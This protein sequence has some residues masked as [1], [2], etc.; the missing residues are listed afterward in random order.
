MTTN[1]SLVRSRRGIALRA[2][3]VLLAMVLML[4]GGVPAAA[5]S[6]RAWLSVLYGGP[7]NLTDPSG[8]EVGE[9]T[10]RGK[11]V[12]LDFG[13][14]SCP[15]ICPTTLQAIAG[16]LDLLGTGAEAVQPLFVTLDPER[17]TPALLAS[18]T[19]LFH[20]RILGLSGTAEQ[21]AA[22]ARAYR[23]EYRKVV[24]KTGGD[25]FMDH[26]TTVYLLDTQGKTVA[27]FGRQSTAEEMTAVIR[28]LLPPQM[29]PA[30]P[31]PRP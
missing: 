1:R 18:Y 2:A 20:P 6:P 10:W 19:A 3:W 25:Y 12:L 9:R 30:A 21:T 16:A 8:R 27:L 17:D 15:D 22:I 11:L 4:A 31:A 26:S 23:V 24:P 5:E 29:P 14:R 7:W 13:Y 28:P